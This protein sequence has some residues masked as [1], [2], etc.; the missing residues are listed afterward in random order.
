MKATRLIAKN[1]NSN[2]FSPSSKKYAEE[3][4]L[5][6]KKEN[7]E[8]RDQIVELKVNQFYHF[9]NKKLKDLI[10]EVEKL[11]AEVSRLK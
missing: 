9:D 5:A 4:F 1:N 2:I 6:L 3:Q 10:T 7:K 11:K 8:L